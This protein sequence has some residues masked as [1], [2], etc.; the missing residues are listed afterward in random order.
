MSNNNSDNFGL[1]IFKYVSYKCELKKIY[2]HI[3]NIDFFISFH[4]IYFS[5][6]F[7]LIITADLRL[8][9]K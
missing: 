6:L 9:T 8:K 4:V 3:V 1:Y 5:L 7:R 2:T